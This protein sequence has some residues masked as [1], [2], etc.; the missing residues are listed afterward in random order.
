MECI[1]EMIPGDRC[2]SFDRLPLEAHP[3]WLFTP[4]ECLGLLALPRIVLI[5]L[6]SLGSLSYAAFGSQGAG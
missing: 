5:V 3:S 6:G 2:L 1:V 4:G